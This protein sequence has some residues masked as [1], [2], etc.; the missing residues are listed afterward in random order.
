[1]AGRP[2]LRAF[3]ARIEREGG[4]D[5]I[6][7]RIRDGMTLTAIGRLY[8][9]SRTMI[10]Q[11]AYLNDERRAAYERAKL[12]SADALADQATEA[13]E[14][15]AES[16]DP[17]P[18]QVSATKNR[19]DHLMRLAAIRNREEYGSGPSVGE[20]VADLGR[21]FLEALRE[22]GRVASGGGIERLPSA[23]PMIEGEYEVEEGTDGD[24]TDAAEASGVGGGTEA[25]GRA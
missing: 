21:V 24:K 18:G 17:S 11:W 4:D 22:H 19:A 6:L 12:D 9:V 5:V 1:M 14:A 10:R 7:D 16:S 3:A 15:L 25:G 8:G 13:H 20:Q 2:K 23:A